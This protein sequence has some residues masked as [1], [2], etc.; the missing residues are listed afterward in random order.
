MV[1]EKNLLKAEAGTVPHSG[2]EGR[3]KTE[4]A[5]AKLGQSFACF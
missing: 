3:L 4:Q 1:I 5:L 2:G